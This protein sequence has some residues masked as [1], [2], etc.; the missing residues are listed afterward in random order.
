MKTNL[1]KWALI[2][3][4]FSMAGAIGGGLFE[5]IVLVPLSSASPRKP[6]S[7]PE[8][9]LC[10]LQFLPDTFQHPLHSR[11]GI[12]NHSKCLDYPRLVYSLTVFRGCAAS[13]RS[14]F[15]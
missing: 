10:L 6:T 7:G 3:L 13:D 12:G 1:A 11:D 14:P 2:L 4:C 8:S 5:H 15:R 9:V